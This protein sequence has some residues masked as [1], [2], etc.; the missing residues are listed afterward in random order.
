MQVVCGH[1]G[2]AVRVD[3]SQLGR[4]AMCPYCNHPLPEP[5]QGDDDAL[6]ASLA[7]QDGFAAVALSSRHGRILF[8]CRHCGK[9][10][11]A[12]VSMADQM[13]ACLG[14]GK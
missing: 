7:N 6:D 4:R 3:P 11:A 1:C 9:R 10:L 5:V 12:P 14:C 2:K 13:S 8:T